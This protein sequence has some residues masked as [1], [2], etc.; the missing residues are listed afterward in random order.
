MWHSRGN[1]WENPL[2]T[3]MVDVKEAR[4]VRLNSELF[5]VSEAERQMYDRYGLSPV[6]VEAADPEKI[7]PHV[8]GADAVC[9][10]S[11]SLPTKVIDSLTNC[12]LI[13]RLGN[14]TDKID[15]AR[16]TERGI[17]V[18]NVPYFCVDEMAD[19]AMAM[20]LS[21]S[22]NIPRMSDYL[23]DGRFRQAR[24]ESQML[25]RLSGQVLGLIG[26]GASA[27]AMARRARP[28][29]LQLL[30][31]RR[32]MT[33]SH[34]EAAELDV[35]VVGLHELLEKSDYVSLHLPLNDATRHLLDLEN[36]LRMK[37]GSF[38]INTSRGAIV[39]EEALT[40]LLDN[41]HLAG[42]GLDTFDIF[43]CFGETEVAPDHPLL[44]GDT[45]LATPHVSGLSKDA[46][47]DIGITSARNLISVLN[48][49]LPL[50]ENIV[51]LDVLAGC[52]LLPHDPS[53][54]E[55]DR[56]AVTQ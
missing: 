41:R 53:L 55:D 33:G 34:A 17:L 50:S 39:D 16:A 23:R 18:S 12:G 32:D 51:N 19:H 30:A 15:V 28:F 3:A 27:K 21:L 45:V 47:A 9:V 24:A 38:L 49:R 37:R 20:L 10:V 43:D 29:G 4:I 14:G 46:M 56:T 54:F 31:T 36:L 52:K 13:S 7:I 8:E 40:E 11:A 22:R 35:E 44:K 5:P 1:Y 6:E 42:A 2:E 26:F 48:G 25:R